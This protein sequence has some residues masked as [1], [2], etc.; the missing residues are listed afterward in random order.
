M[1]QSTLEDPNVLR[2][3]G[4]GELAAIELR[5]VTKQFHVYEHRPKSLRERFVRT[6]SRQSDRGGNPH[7]CL[8]DISFTVGSGE[9]WALVG[10]NGAGKSTLLRLLAGIYWPSA[11]VVITRGRLATVM[12]LGAGFHP[13][14]TGRE[15][16]QM[17][18]AILGLAG[19]VLTQF[20]PGIVEFA[21]IGHF[22]DTPLK[23]YSSGMR[24]RLAFA[25]ATAVQ[26]DILL[27]DEILAVGDGEF[28]ERS[29]E[30]LRFFHAAGCTLV[31]AAHALAV[32]ANLA[33]KAIWLDQGHVRGQGAA[34]DVIDGYQGT[35]GTVDVAG[36]G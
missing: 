10:P 7:F 15:N 5:R 31:F 30:R 6:A 21:G 17:Y 19:S 27:L 3:R 11:G 25:V 32:A 36:G 28:R 2:S 13:E 9:S 26:P 16:V 4:E 24:V 22:M 18:W 1:T 8:S 29:L 34:R 23:Y 33:T 14:L 20:Y 12:E 35:L